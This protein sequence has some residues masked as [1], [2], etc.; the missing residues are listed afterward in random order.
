MGCL[1]YDI[2]IKFYSW[3]A[4]IIYIAI[5]SILF[6]IKMKGVSKEIKS[7][8]SIYRSIVLFL[9]FYIG[10][11]IMFL[12]S[13]LYYVTSYFSLGKTTIFERR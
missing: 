6:L 5:L 4:V 2:T 11:R 3:V 1:P 13:D 9:W 12:F 7:Q 10:V 8:K